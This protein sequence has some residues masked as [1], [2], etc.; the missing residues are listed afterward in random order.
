MAYLDKVKLEELE[1]AGFTDSILARRNSA[2]VIIAGDTGTGKTHWSLS[3][4]KPLLYQSTDFGDDGVIQKFEDAGQIIRPS[5]GDYKLEM[6]HELRPFTDREE[7]DAARRAREG[8]VAAW[9]HKNFYEPFHDDYIKA[10]DMGVRSVVWDTALEV[11]EYVRLSVYGASATTS[12]HQRTLANAKM[13]EL[14]RASNVR[15]VNLIMVN[16]LKPKWE[17]YFD[18]SGNMK[19]RQSPTEHEMQGFDK[20][21]ELVA[22]NLWTK[23]TL[24]STPG[25]LPTFELQVKKCR[26]NA[27][28]VGM[29]IEA[30]PWDDVMAMLIPSVEK[31]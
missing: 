30:L 17:S 27:E 13:K 4:P 5:R 23:M 21:P 26:D 14:I 24:S 12:D 11:W 1:K 10:M 8:K 25:D 31:W 28:F 16:R 22:I 19:W 6:P 3:A 18:A 29:T 9:V 7:S 2:A 15:G 20:A